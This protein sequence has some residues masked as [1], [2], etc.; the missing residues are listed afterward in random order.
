MLQLPDVLRMWSYLLKNPHN[1][2]MGNPQ[3]K[4]EVTF[5]A[6]SNATH[7]SDISLQCLFLDFHSLYFNV[8]NQLL[9]FGWMM[10]EAIPAFQ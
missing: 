8:Y 9:G 1:Q 10:C 7:Y 2:E 3:L 4:Q 6:R 5:C